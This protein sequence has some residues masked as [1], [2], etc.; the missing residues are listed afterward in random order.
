MIDKT[1]PFPFAKKIVYHDPLP[2]VDFLSD[3][4]WNIVE[5]H[6]LERVY[7]LGNTDTDF[8]TAHIIKFLNDLLT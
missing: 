1:L 6:C 7:V 3:P 5:R 4:S 2:P 8:N